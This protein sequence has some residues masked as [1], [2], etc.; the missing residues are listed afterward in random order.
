M[1]KNITRTV[2]FISLIS[3]FNDFS[4]E[5]LYPIIPLYLQQIGYGSV[6][7]GILEG[8]AECVAGLSKIYMGSLSD[9]FQRRLPFVQLGYALSVLS[10]P[11]IG[12]T[13][14]VGLIFLGRSLD[15]TGK[16]IRSGARDAL[17]GD[18]STETTRAEVFGLHRS[19]D[20]AGAVLGPIVAIVY[21]YYNPEDYRSLF[22][23]TL[24]PGIV[25][26]FFT[27]QIKEKKR[28]TNPVKTF[29]IRKHFSYFKQAPSPYLKLLIP[30]LL[31]ALVNSSD[32]FLLMRAKQIGMGERDV[33]LLY[34]V[35][36]LADR[37]GHMKI[38]ILG[39]LI[40]ALSYILFAS[41]NDVWITV[42]VFIFYGLFYAF[43]Q[44]IIKALLISRVPSNE[45]SS[46]IGFY[47]GM[48]SF[49]L[50]IANG[51]AGW[52][53]F[54]FGSQAMLLY[55][56]IVTFIVILLLL[57]QYNQWNSKKVIILSNES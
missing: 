37:I 5:M 18:E 50:L 33:L 3:L 22:L 15:R 14:I 40:Y 24:I 52:I 9:S 27:F 12:L 57:V 48:N 19:M 20:T 6:L 38:L 25:A 42:T 51:L 55:S 54:Q 49:G 1:F 36:K 21:L 10:R 30:L 32:M 39:L 56:S 26:L 46:A 8:I 29:S 4:S 17:L 35:G 16:G 28:T 7:I 45:K 11:L 47:E 23:I 34:L 2:W 13:S 41:F 44:G 43:T 53:W 31:F